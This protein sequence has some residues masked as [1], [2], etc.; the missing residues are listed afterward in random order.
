MTVSP[1]YTRTG[2]SQHVTKDTQILHLVG[3]EAAG[4]RHIGCMA[5]C[6]LL[7][8]GLLGRGLWRLLGLR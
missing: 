4:L 3:E 8:R 5:N 1:K 7:G 2:P 6:G